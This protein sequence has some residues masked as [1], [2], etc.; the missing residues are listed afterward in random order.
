[1]TP[2]LDQDRVRLTFELSSELAPDVMNAVAELATAECSSIELV[3]IEPKFL[4]RPKPSEPA[5]EWVNPGT[6][7][8]TEVIDG[9][10]GQP[11]R[12]VTIRNLDDFF[13]ANGVN[14]GAPGGHIINSLA[15][16][17]HNSDHE[18]DPYV[19]RP[20]RNIR[21]IS[22]WHQRFHQTAGIRVDTAPE[23]IRKIEARE[24]VP[25]G[26]GKKGKRKQLLEAYFKN[27]FA[28]YQYPADTT[29][30]EK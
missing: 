12:V 11:I 10:T 5:R 9:A 23:L 14:E 8:F 3:D 19:Y 17:Y 1:M 24:I 30:T 15:D 27:F 13:R 22:R 25:T 29:P 2:E 4:K 21:D 7:L 16:L 18:L 26:I 28:N 20:P 6:P